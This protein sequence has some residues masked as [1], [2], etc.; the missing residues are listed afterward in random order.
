M[1]HPPKTPVVGI[2]TVST[3]KKRGDGLVLCHMIG[4]DP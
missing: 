2:V 4:K 1:C 3:E